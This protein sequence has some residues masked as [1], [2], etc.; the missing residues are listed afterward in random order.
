MQWFTELSAVVQILF[1]G[2]GALIVV[3]LVAL[4]FYIVHNGIRIKKADTVI[5][6]NEP[7]KELTEAKPDDKA[8]L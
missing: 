6:I 7:E 8:T 4:G 5:E 1:I 3:G 2:F